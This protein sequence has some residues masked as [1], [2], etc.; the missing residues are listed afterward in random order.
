MNF[1][2]RDGRTLRMLQSRIL[3]FLLLNFIKFLSASLHYDTR[4]AE[5]MRLAPYCSLARKYLLS[6]QR[7]AIG[8]LLAV[9][10]YNNSGN[11]PRTSM[12]G[13]EWEEH[14]GFVHSELTASIPFRRR[15]A[16]ERENAI[17]QILTNKCI[18]S[19]LLNDTVPF[20][21]LTHGLSSEEQSGL[22]RLGLAVIDASEDLRSFFRPVI[23]L[24]Q[25]QRMPITSSRPIQPQRRADGWSTFYKF[26][27]WRL[28][29][30]FDQIL[31]LDADALLMEDPTPLLAKARDGGIV[32]QAAMEGHA[33]YQRG[34]CTGGCTSGGINTHLM[35]LKTNQTI[36][37]E[38]LNKAQALDYIPFTNTDQDVLENYFCDPIVCAKEVPSFEITYRGPGLVQIDCS[39][40]GANLV[41]GGY[42]GVIQHRHKG[43]KRSEVKRFYRDECLVT[44]RKKEF[45]T[46]VNKEPFCACVLEWAQRLKEPPR[47]ISQPKE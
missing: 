46:D 26:V 40:C 19:R 36:Y 45:Q 18:Q 30:F 3:L 44:N 28:D 38:L 34:S 37:K 16:L 29:Q 32:F 15:L 21:V 20:V 1:S 33:G 8:T 5:A 7:T 14:R 13:K 23:T 43:L 25:V 10:D 42:Q 41:R 47:H 22:C 6:D 12:S 11:I 4:E 35:V 31:F 9:G 39:T 24:K 17:D 27:F 2:T